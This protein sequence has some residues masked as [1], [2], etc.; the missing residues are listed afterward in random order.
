MQGDRLDL[1][2]QVAR[3]TVRK[4]DGNDW[5]GVVEFY[6]AR[7]W[8]VPMHHATDIPDVERSIGRMQAQGASVLFPALQEAF[9]GLKDLDARYKH[10]LVISDGGVA[11]DRYQ[12]LIRHIA[13][14]RINVSTVAVGGQVD[15]EKSMAEW[16]RIGRGRFYSVPDEFNLVDLDF[17][18][19]QTKPEPGY[20]AALSPCA[21][22]RAR[23][24]G[25]TFPPRAC[26]RCRD[27]CRPAPG[28]RRR[29]CCAPMVAIPILSSWPV[30]RGVSPR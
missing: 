6:G 12:Q 11:E 25:A 1:A 13:D 20:R 17:K 5:V 7:Q 29:R 10:I 19:P 21:P 8:S 16:A 18:Q 24:S 23:V 14:N 3:Q 26:R 9:Y 22:R 28:P 30:G 15:D 2:K 27:T 4:L